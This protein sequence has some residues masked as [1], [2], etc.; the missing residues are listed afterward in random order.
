MHDYFDH[1]ADTLKNILALNIVNYDDTNLFN[2]PE[3]RK[4]FTKRGC[5]YPERILNQTMS[6]VSFIFAVPGD[7][8]YCLVM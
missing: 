1:L 8:Y 3:R 5:K 2:D 7:G 4:I 6:T